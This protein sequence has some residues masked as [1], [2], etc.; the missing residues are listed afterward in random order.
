MQ[1]YIYSIRK[2]RQGYI[3]LATGGATNIDYQKT[4]GVREPLDRMLQHIDN[5]YHIQSSY[6]IAKGTLETE[7]SESLEQA[8]RSGGACSCIFSYNA[9]EGDCYGVGSENFKKFSKIWE[10]S[11]YNPQMQF[12][13]LIYI[14]HFRKSYSAW[15]DKAGSQGEF[16]LKIKN[17]IPKYRSL[18]KE[19]QDALENASKQATWSSRAFS[20]QDDHA[21]DDLFWPEKLL[22][23]SIAEHYSSEFI[24]LSEYVDVF[25]STL[26]D[27][28]NWKDNEKVDIKDLNKV[29]WKL[30]KKDA[31]KNKIIEKIKEKKKE[32]KPI[33]EVLNSLSIKLILPT[34][35]EMSEV[36]QKITDGLKK[37]QKRIQVKNL[38]QYE[39]VNNEQRPIPDWY[40][41]SL[42]LPQTDATKT[43]KIHCASRAIREL[44]IHGG[45]DAGFDVV[46][47]HYSEIFG[48]IHIAEKFLRNV[49]RLKAITEGAGQL[50]VVNQEAV[51]KGTAT[52][53]WFARKGVGKTLFWT[54][55]ER[56]SEFLNADA[57][58][59]D[60]WGLPIY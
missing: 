30:L 20:A 23:K 42:V 36:A 46:A 8:I 10:S 15:N 24:K 41:Q 27:P 35:E 58:T 47:A 38:V 5:A 22:G 45:K 54:P 51:D 33:E 13:E 60:I 18:P 26:S 53:A 6:A 44:N 9:S 57:E 43:V 55:P 49:Y 2:N 56:V 31:I 11:V 48:G 59:K 1:G 12:A 16:R 25:Y 29:V 4:L 3:G 40:P 21:L 52:K 7:S 28:D 50:Y 39:Y 17:L 14:Y 19:L 34:E 37:G 32:L